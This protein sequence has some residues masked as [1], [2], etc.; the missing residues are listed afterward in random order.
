MSKID[1]EIAFVY[2]HV[3]NAVTALEEREDIDTA[4]DS[5]FA[6]LGSLRDLLELQLDPEDATLNDREPWD[7]LKDNDSDE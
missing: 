2:E 5:L 7:E 3:N 1:K 4:L 6:C